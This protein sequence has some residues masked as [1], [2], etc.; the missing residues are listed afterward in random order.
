[1]NEIVNK[2]L[3]RLRNPKALIILGTAGI[4]LILLSSFISGGEEEATV[5][6]SDEI[7]AREYCEMLE[8]DICKMVTDI[9]G[10]KNVTA[11]VTLESGIRYSYA[12]TREKISSDKTEK[13][14]KS[15]DSELKEGYITVKTA[16]GG[17]QALLITAEMPEIRGVAIV[18]EGGDSEIINEKILNTVTAALNITSKRVY[19]CGRKTK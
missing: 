11:V 8:A 10:S 5:S 13:E 18:C 2:Y 19:I 14:S 4:L 15:S 6:A 7:T 17:E 16:D 1:M 3:S 12:D 9:T